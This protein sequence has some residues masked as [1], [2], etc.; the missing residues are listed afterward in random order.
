M[1]GIFAYI[2]TYIASDALY[3]SYY[4][5]MKRGPDD[6]VLKIIKNNLVFGFHR[7][8]INDTSFKGN[9]PLFH[10]NK[11]LSVICNGEIYNYKELKEKYSIQTYSNSDCEILLYL[12][13]NFG[14]EKTIQ[15]IDSESFA[16]CIYDGITN[17]VYIAR[18]R[19]GVRPLFMCKTKKNEYIFASESK[20][21][22]D[23][24]DT[25]EE[26]IQQFAP[27]SYMSINLSNYEAT[28]NIPYYLYEYP[29]IKYDMETIYENIRNKLGAAVKKRLLSDRPIGCL[30]SGGLDS[31]LISA[32]VSKHYPEYTL[33]TFSIGFK[34]SPDLHYANI[35]AKHIKS[36]H[37]CIELS[38]EDFLKNIEKTIKMIESYDTTTVRASVGN[39]LISEF[40]RN[41]TDCKVVFNGDYSDEVCGGYKYFYNAPNPLSFDEECKRLV[42]NICYFDSLRSDRSISGNGLEARVP[43]ADNDFV[44]LYQSIP[45]E[46]RMPKTDKIEKYLLRKA[47]DD[48]NLLPYE[49]LWRKKEAFSDGVSKPEKSWHKTIQEYVDTLVSDNEADISNLSKESFFY[50]KIFDNEY[51]N[52]SNIIPY[53]WMPKW[54]GNI[55]DPSAREI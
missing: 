47:F 26:I 28:D 22:V 5:T 25:N 13:A 8:S 23:L 46:M 14:I 40:I 3:K 49:I 33:K 50:K 21:I 30:L 48:E 1:C 17:K 45:P 42:S 51:P 43:F 20:S 6:N 9:Q 27:S 39:V 16:F 44:S 4:K 11:P 2:G 31:S 54:C 29:T 19:F 15:L 32:L 41:N 18:D 55:K 53:Y 52:H 12:Y 38:E 7:L 37:H 10:P 34:G 24:V 35:V 36:I